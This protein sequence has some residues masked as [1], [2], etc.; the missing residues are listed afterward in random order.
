MRLESGPADHWSHESGIHCLSA[1]DV[2]DVD[3]HGSGVF[4]PH[5]HVSAT[6]R[7]LYP[8]RTRC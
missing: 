1:V 7:L 2:A 3:Y 4:A 6:M 5:Y 8:P